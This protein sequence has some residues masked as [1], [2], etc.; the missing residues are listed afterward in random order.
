MDESKEFAVVREDV[1]GDVGACGAVSVKET[2][3][4]F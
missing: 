3:T 4:G 1:G 2:V